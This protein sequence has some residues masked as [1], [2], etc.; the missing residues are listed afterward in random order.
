[1]ALNRS[2]FDTTP[3]ER[4]VRTAQRLLVYRAIVDDTTFVPD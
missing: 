4:V 2:A 3:N 1:M